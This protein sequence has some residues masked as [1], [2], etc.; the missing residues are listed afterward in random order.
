MHDLNH[1]ESFAITCALRD[2]AKDYG[3][4][5]VKLRDLPIGAVFASTFISAKKYAFAYA[6][7]RGWHENERG[8]I[9]ATDMTAFEWYETADEGQPTREYTSVYIA[10]DEDCYVFDHALDAYIAAGAASES[11]SMDEFLDE[12]GKS[13]NMSQ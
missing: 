1:E 2:I 13:I 4:R 12:C 6:A 8:S 9:N 7:R 3:A 11:M 10:K 5:T